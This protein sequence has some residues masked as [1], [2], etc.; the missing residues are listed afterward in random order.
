MLAQATG[1]SARGCAFWNEAP[2]SLPW[3]CPGFL[4]EQMLGQINASLRQLGSSP[5][6]S[7][8]RTWEPNS[9]SGSCYSFQ[10]CVEPLHFLIL[11]SFRGISKCVHLTPGI[12]WLRTPKV[13]VKDLEELAE[14]KRRKPNMK[15]VNFWFPLIN[16][17]LMIKSKG[18]E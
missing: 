12:S 10:L 14:R 3:L 2:F 17:V 7:P 9:F 15:K 5:S 13:N 16:E 6:A 1:R 18:G 8:P 11:S 4:T